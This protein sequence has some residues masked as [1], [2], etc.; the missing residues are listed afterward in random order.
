MIPIF[1]MAIIFGKK[2][3]R[4]FILNIKSIAL[5]KGTFFNKHFIKWG[6][7]FNKMEK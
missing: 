7:K 5:K 2:I 3:S 4:F 1:K 6:H